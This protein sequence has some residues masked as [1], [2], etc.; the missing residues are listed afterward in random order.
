MTYFLKLFDPKVKIENLNCL[1]KETF[2]PKFR[3]TVDMEFTGVLQ[4]DGHSPADRTGDL[5]NTLLN[6]LRADLRREIDR[7]PI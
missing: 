2:G 6:N 4:E 5:I 7:N 1:D 3:L